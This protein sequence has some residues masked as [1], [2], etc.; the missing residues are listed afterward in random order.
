MYS[1]RLELELN[2]GLPRGE[3]GADGKWT[4]PGSKV[5]P[6]RIKGEPGA[7]TKRGGRRCPPEAAPPGVPASL[8]AGKVRPGWERSLGRGRVGADP[9]AGKKKCKK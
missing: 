7:E 3:P 4:R 5:N 8:L 1:I 9:G 2:L 6:G